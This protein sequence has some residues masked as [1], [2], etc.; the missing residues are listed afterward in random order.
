MRHLTKSLAL[1]TGFLAISISPV[2]TIAGES[3]LRVDDPYVRLVPPG[4]K[5]TGAFMTIHNAGNAERKLVKATSPVSD[6]VQLHTHMNDNGV[7]KMREVPDIAVPAGGKVELKPGSYHIMLIE[8]KSELKEGDRVPVTLRFDDDST[9][10]VDATVRKLPTMMPA[11][12]KMDA[13]EM[14][15]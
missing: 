15:H 2:S 8:M 4:T 9:S 11:A 10:Q 12:N 3:A 7:M 14:K 13:G 6:K 1:L 5:T